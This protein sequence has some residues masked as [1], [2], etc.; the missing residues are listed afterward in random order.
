MVVGKRG[1]LVRD[2]V[3]LSSALVGEIAYGERVQWTVD[4]LP[5]FD[6]VLLP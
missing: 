5:L 6:C 1:A 3:E 4:Q 2:G